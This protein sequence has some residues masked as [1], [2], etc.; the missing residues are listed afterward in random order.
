MMPLRLQPRSFRP[1]NRS[2]DAWTGGPPDAHRRN[3]PPGAS[4]HQGPT[5]L[6]HCAAGSFS[7]PTS[8]VRHRPASV[9]ALACAAE[10]APS[11]SALPA[12]A[13]TVE[14]IPRRTPTASPPQQ[15][16]C[17]PQSTGS[18]VFPERGPAIRSAPRCLLT[19]KSSS[20]SRT[21]AAKTSR[22]RASTSSKST[23][24]SRSPNDARLQLVRPPEGADQRTIRSPRGFPE[25]L[26]DSAR[27]ESSGGLANDDSPSASPSSLQACP[28]PSTAAPR[29]DLPL[30]PPLMHRARLRPTVPRAETA[31]RRPQPAPTSGAPRCPTA[32]SIH[33]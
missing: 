17:G 12:S 7:P 30:H 13:S 25:D 6:A 19:T 27:A 15:D 8:A 33:A 2:P 18:V 29:V 9:S 21:S 28:S 4:D 26:A 22:D 16:P 14:C 5:L 24:S 32:Y 10:T 11:R 23:S 20:C 31:S 3:R 1:R